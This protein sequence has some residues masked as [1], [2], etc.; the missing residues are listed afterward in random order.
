M[1]APWFSK[2]TENETAMGNGED[3]NSKSK[4]REGSFAR[5]WKVFV[6]LYKVTRKFIWKM[7][8][9]INDLLFSIYT[10]ALCV[11]LRSALARVLLR[12]L[13]DKLCQS[14]LIVIGNTDRVPLWNVRRLSQ[15]IA[16]S[17]L[18]V[19]KNC[20]HIPHEERGED[21]LNIVKRFLQETSEDREK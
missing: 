7:F 1:I 15:A 13:V 18:E 11:F 19:I 21:F 9:R 20:G 10:K 2:E 4:Y 3:W 17:R 8:K 14:E 12:N 16:S 5:I 6:K